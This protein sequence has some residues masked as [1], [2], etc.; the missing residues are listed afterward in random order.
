MGQYIIS[1]LANVQFTQGLHK[2]LEKCGNIKTVSLCPGAVDT[3]IF[4][5]DPTD[6]VGQD[7]SNVVVSYVYSKPLKTHHK[8][9]C[10]L[11]ICPSNS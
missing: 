1:K 2:R 7:G 10:M 11:L 4:N 8:R 3:P 6:N 9:T 5:V